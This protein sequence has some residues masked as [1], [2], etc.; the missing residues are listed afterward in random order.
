[1]YT[2][3][4]KIR[5]VELFIEYDFG[6]QSVI[7]ELGYPCRGS[8]YNWYREYPENGNDIPDANPYERYGDGL[9]G[10]AVDHYFERGRCLSRTCR[11]PGYPSK[12]LLARWIDELGPGRR[13]VNRTSRGI[14]DAA[15]ENAVVRL[16]ARAEAA[17]AIADDVG[18]ERA[19]PCN[20]KRELPGKE[21]ATKMTGKKGDMAVEE[22]EALR[23]SL[24]A[25]IDRLELKRAVPEG[26][27]ELLGKG[28]SADPTTLTTGEKTILVESLRPAHK[29][30]DLLDAV[31][32]AKG[33]RRYQVEALSRPDKYEHL[34]IRICEIFHESHGR[35]GHRRIHATLRVEGVRVSEKVVSRIMAEEGLAACRPKRRRRSSYKG[36]IGDAPE[37]LVKRRFHASAPNEL[38]L[39]DI[40][41]LSIPAGKV[42]LSPIIDC[43]DGKAVAHAASTSPNAE[44]V[45]TML[46]E[47]ADTLDPDDHPVSHSDRGCHY[48]WPGWIERCES[49]GIRRSMPAKGCSPDNSAMEGFFG[50]LK[51]EF[52]YGRDWK[53]WSI[54]RFIEALC[55]YIEWYNKDRIKLSLG[56]MSPAQYRRSL[57]LAA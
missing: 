6:P 46:D 31:G 10:V 7:N 21:A 8:L 32:L 14:A 44:L 1:M 53:G 48:R 50:R 22:P 20:W 16:V 12:E 3:E 23:A 36:E 55:D 33:S 41:E 37:N 34:R 15:K 11:M 38:W 18:V 47:A 30:K 43:L 26:T 54:G 40:T 28:P 13:V 52:F 17:Q 57:G 25:D 4:D 42:C 2:R 19:A 29:L 49:H 51:V 24:E 35:Y 5:A 45:N 27:V 9:K 56:G 39:T